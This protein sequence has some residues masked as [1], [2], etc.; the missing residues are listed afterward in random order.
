MRRD[1]KLGA[2]LPG[3]LVLSCGGQSPSV[4]IPA[5]PA[6]AVDLPVVE[7]P[8]DPSIEARRT[9]TNPGGMWMPQQ[10]TLPGHADAFTRLGVKLDPKQLGNPLAAP[11]AAI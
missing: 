2:L 4:T 10:M 3:V 6:T 8:Q 7:R 9:Y 1:M 5:P 11:L